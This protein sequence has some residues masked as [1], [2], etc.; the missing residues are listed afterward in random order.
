MAR[1]S[2][3]MTRVDCLKAANEMLKQLPKGWKPEV[4]ENCGWHYA[5]QREASYGESHRIHGYA[6][7]HYW[8]DLRIGGTQFE[9]SGTT[10]VIAVENALKKAQVIADDL[11]QT[12]HKL[13]IGVT[14]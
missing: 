2:P 11:G 14:S 12:K 4:W 10:P 1:W 6:E 7:K 13:G 9:A 3:T 5:V 8:A